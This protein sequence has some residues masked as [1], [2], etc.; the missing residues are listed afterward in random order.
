MNDYTSEQLVGIFEDQ[1]DLKNL[2]GKVCYTMLLKREK[3]MVA[4]F[5]SR[6]ED[7]CLGLND[8]YYEG[9]AAVEG[10]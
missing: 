8:G 7:L 4:D 3:T 1:R 2:M 9:R 10:Y 5:W 6:R